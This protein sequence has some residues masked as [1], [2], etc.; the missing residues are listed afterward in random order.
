MKCTR[1]KKDIHPLR[2]KALPSTK[3]CI[4]CSTE[5]PMKGRNVTYGHGDH[6]YTE[7]EILPDDTYRE[8]YSAEDY[9]AKKILAEKYMEEDNSLSLQQALAIVISKAEEEEEN[10][11]ESET[12]SDDSAE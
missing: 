12:N 5:Q 9:S 3:V 1:C 2:L 11:D 8:L 6:T 10:N 7:I 4:T